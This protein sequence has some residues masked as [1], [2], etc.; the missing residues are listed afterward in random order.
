VDTGLGVVGAVPVKLVA[1]LQGA[2]KKPEERRVVWMAV[3]GGGHRLAVQ[4]NRLVEV[5]APIFEAGLHLKGGSEVVQD[6]RS[7]PAVSRYCGN[8]LPADDYRLAK[9]IAAAVALEA[10]T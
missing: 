5:G 9:I 6:A 7:V 10:S 1:L 3:F 2:A 4:V 8:G